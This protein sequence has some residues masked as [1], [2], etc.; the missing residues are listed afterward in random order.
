MG[1]NDLSHFMLSVNIDTITDKRNNLRHFPYII[2]IMFIYVCA[3]LEY[4][5]ISI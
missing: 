3:T 4:F 5:Y 1:K 2:T